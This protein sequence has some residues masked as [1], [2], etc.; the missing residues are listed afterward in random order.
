MGRL[1]SR[2]CFGEPCDLLMFGRLCLVKS[3]ICM[4]SR[5]EVFEH[6]MLPTADEL[7]EEADFSFQQKTVQWL[8]FDHVLCIEI[9]LGR[10]VCFL[11]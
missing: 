11:L 9:L 1:Y 3:K 7:Y 5:Q 10:L 2:C 8:R 6:F 4:S